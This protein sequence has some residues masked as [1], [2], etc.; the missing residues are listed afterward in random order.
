LDR[1]QFEVEL[2]LPFYKAVAKLEKRLIKCAIQPPTV[3]K[4]T[5][6][7]F[8]RRSRSIMSGSNGGNL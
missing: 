2:L 3:S 1:E 7:C 5:V 4:S 6:V 8:A